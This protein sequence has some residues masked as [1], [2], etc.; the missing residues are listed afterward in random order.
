MVRCFQQ[1]HFYAY[2][3]TIVV[4]GMATLPRIVSKSSRALSMT[5]HF[6]YFSQ[7]QY[8]TTTTPITMLWWMSIPC[9]KALIFAQVEKMLA[10][11]V[12][13]SFTPANYIWLKVSRASSIDPCSV[14]PVI[15]AFHETTFLWGIFS[16]NSCA[17]STHPHFAYTSTRQ[18][19]LEGAVYRFME[20]KRMCSLGL[21]ELAHFLESFKRLIQ[22]IY[23]VCI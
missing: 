11:V 17:L 7:L 2:S 15:M 5:A 1:I 16:N 18:L 13:P 6:A 3:A 8:Q 10:K 12:E 20:G 9:S 4:N 14:Y 23:F 22:Q 19:Q 21:R